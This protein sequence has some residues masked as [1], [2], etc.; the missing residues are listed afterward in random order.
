M[1]EPYIRPLYQNVVGDPMARLIGKIL[2][3]NKI[4]VIG[5]LT[6]VGI[7]PA[8]FYE[9][10]LLALILL[11]L[12]GLFD[13]LDGTVARLFYQH[14]PY[15]TAL[16]IVGDR[17]VEFAI[18]LGL[19]FVSSED[20]A[21]DVL[22][23]LG[24]ILICVTSFLVVG[25]FSENSS[26]KSFHYSPG[27]MERPEAFVFFAAMILFPEFFHMLAFLFTFLVTLTAVIRMAEFKSVS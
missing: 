15:G 12:S 17:I 3:P 22:I 16:D 21:F 19:Y 9:Q 25:I 20:R 10:T 27:L 2:S 13:T 6:G 23:M 24:S 5:V 8:L 11:A 1:I 26:S 4:T 14:S 18:L 7:A